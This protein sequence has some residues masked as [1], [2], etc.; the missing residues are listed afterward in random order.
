MPLGQPAVVLRTKSKLE[1]VLLASYL[2]A[3]CTGPFTSWFGKTHE[4]CS[5]YFFLTNF[6]FLENPTHA[7]KTFFLNQL[8]K[9]SVFYLL[10]SPAP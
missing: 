7:L 9:L 5:P 4:G 2:Q 3:S 8:T 6:C 10:S 1:L